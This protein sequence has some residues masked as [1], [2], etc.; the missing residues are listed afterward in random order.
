MVCGA[1]EIFFHKD[2]S[3]KGED[4]IFTCLPLIR[5]NNENE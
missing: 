3:L 5:K 1:G 4:K 2:R